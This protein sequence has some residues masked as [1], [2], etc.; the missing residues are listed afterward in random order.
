VSEWYPRPRTQPRRTMV[1]L[2]C[3]HVRWE[4]FRGDQVQP[5]RFVFCR[6]CLVSRRIMGVYDW[7]PCA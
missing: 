7:G 4:G 1:L 2:G 5:W 6:H 3:G